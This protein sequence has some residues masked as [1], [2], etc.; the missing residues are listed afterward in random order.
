MITRSKRMVVCLLCALLTPGLALSDEADERQALKTRI[1]A[2]DASLAGLQTPAASEANGGEMALVSSEMKLNETL[3]LT[4]NHFVAGLRF[5]YY[6]SGGVISS[7]LS[8][9]AGYALLALFVSVE[10]T[11]AESVAT[12]DLLNAE[13]VYNNDD[14]CDARDSFYHLTSRGVYAG[15]LKYIPPKTL[16]EGCIL[17][18]LPEEIAAEISMSQILLRITYKDTVVERTLQENGSLLPKEMDAIGY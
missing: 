11:S 3:T 16:V 18:A 7:T 2:L 12:A 4:V 1:E 5:R 14:L 13:I 9:K 10:N 8:A 6:P 17:F 15:D